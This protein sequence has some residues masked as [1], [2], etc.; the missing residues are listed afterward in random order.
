[1]DQEKIKKAL[2]SGE[3]KAK[4]L[5]QK[6]VKE[7]YDKRATT[8]NDTH[9]LGIQVNLI[10][11]VANGVLV[12]RDEAECAKIIQSILLNVMQFEVETKFLR[13]QKY[14]YLREKIS[15]SLFR[16]KSGD[17]ILDNS[18]WNFYKES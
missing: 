7:H 1:M 10:S 16:V 6:V 2:E 18:F 11:G 4:E 9:P 12:V 15:K 17:K 5:L 13:K 8:I 14:V 3:A